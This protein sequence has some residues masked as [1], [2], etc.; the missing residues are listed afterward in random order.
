M[1]VLTASGITDLVNLTLK[2]LGR[3]KIQNIAQDY[4]SYVLF[5]GMFKKGKMQIDSGYAIQRSLQYKLSDSFRHVGLYED[6][7][8]N[9]ENHTVLMSVPWVYGNTNWSFNE[10]EVTH[11]QGEAMIANIIKPRRFGA[12]MDMVQKLEQTG[13]SAPTS[14]SG[15]ETKKPYGI[16]YWIVKNSSTGF[17]GGAPSGHT[18]VGGVDLTVATKFKNYTAQYSAVSKADLISLMRTGHRKCAFKS[19]LPGTPEYTMGV[20]GQYKYFTNEAVVSDIEDVGEAQNENLG[21]D[22]ASMEGGEMS[23]RRHPIVYVP[24]LD[25]DT[26]NPVYGI[27]HSTF[28]AVVLKGWNMKESPKVQSGTQHLT[29]TYHIDLAYNYLCFDRRRN[30]VFATA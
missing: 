13:W 8:T 23:F 26:Q 1:A 9:I 3:Y 19:P 18:T 21:R 27:D 4:T 2:D 6:D 5:S 28:A 10:L 20:A 25:D 22:I 15:N 24:Q 12:M 17:N 7:V 30:Q 16:P 11:N 29:F 14:T